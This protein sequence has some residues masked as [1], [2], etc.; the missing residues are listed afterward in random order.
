MYDPEVKWQND[1]YQECHTHFVEDSGWP[2]NLSLIS[3]DWTWNA[4]LITSIYATTLLSHLILVILTTLKS[5]FN[6][7]NASTKNTK[8]LKIE[9][10][11]AIR[12]E[13]MTISYKKDKVYNNVNIGDQAN[14]KLI[15][16]GNVIK[17]K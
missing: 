6:L 15:K 1:T 3:P 7:T 2:E 11:K 14:E 10:G 9:N 13:G 4:I 8:T 17:R 12:V 5:Q 16:E